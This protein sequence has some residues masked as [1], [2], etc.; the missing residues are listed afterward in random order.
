MK[1]IIIGEPITIS[2]SKKE[3]DVFSGLNKELFLYQKDAVYF[4]DSNRGPGTKK[5]YAISTPGF[6]LSQL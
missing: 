4:I 1:K 5:G 6:T 2:F 3:K